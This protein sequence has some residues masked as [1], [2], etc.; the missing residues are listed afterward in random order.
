MT[1]TMIVVFGFVAMAVVASAQ[2][3]V[4]APSTYV[5]LLNSYRLVG[6]VTLAPGQAKQATVYQNRV[7]PAVT[8]IAVMH[9]SK[10]GPLGV[11]QGAGLCIEGAIAFQGMAAPVITISD[12][13][14]DGRD[15][16]IGTEGAVAQVLYGNGL[17]ACQ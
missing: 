13:N 17:A 10:N 8:V 3:F 2:T 16:L 6:T 11:N 9:P 12:V 14:G 5:D 15:D 7:W 1:K 4:A